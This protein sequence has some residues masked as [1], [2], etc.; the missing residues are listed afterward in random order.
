MARRKVHHAKRKAAPRKNTAKRRPRRVSGIGKLNISSLAMDVA[1]IAGGVFLG[2]EVSN[3]GK[4]MFPTLSP[5]MMAVAQMAIGVVVP[6]VIKSKIGQDVGNG[7]I[8]VG[9]LGLLQSTGMI[10][11]VGSDTM[12]YRV[13]RLSGAPGNRLM[14]VAGAPG[15]M[16]MSVAG[17]KRQANGGNNFPNTL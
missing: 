13:N 4:T 5:T 7:V 15:N 16:L 6:M 10:A 9:A 11:G 3:M 12:T 1:G 17:M 8:A 14:S 2:R